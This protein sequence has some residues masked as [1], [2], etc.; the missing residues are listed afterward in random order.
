MSVSGVGT[1]T[2]SS[3]ASSSTAASSTLS[4]DDFLKLLVTELEDQN[5]IDPTN[6]ND[7]MNQLVSYAN[8]S[9][10]Q[11]MNTQL[12]TLLT[13]F[14]SLISANAIGYMGHTVEAKNDTAALQGGSATWG[15]SLNADAANATITIKD[16]SGATVWS[17]AG[18]T[19]AGA[20]SFTWDGKDSSGKQLADGGKYTIEISATD[21]S[22]SSVYGYTTTI[23]K[24]DGIDSSS[25]TTMLDIGGVQ[26]S[27][28]SII[29][30]KS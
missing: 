22:G 11:T 16:A 29:G 28:D 20:H 17:G 30:I 24:V 21:K 5:P 19:S 18:N 14:N 9:Q 25:G 26:V 13:S 6:T 10:Q 12:S 1:S 15:Y 8:F 4:T 27:L 7:F 2:A 23:G 3:A